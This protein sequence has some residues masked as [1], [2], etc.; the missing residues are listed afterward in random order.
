[1]P[2]IVTFHPD[3]AEQFIAE[4]KQSSYSGLVGMTKPGSYNYYWRLRFRFAAAAHLEKIVVKFTFTSMAAYFGSCKAGLHAADVTSLPG[5]VDVSLSA[6][7]GT[8]E[9]VG[10]FEANRPYYIWLWYAGKDYTTAKVASTSAV[11]IDGYCIQYPVTLPS[12]AGYTVAPVS[13]YTTSVPYGDDFKFM[14]AIA[15]GYAAGPAF[16]VKANGVVLTAVDGVY[17]I[18][19]ITYA[20]TVTVEG[21]TAAYA[22]T[23]TQGEGYTLTPYGGATSPVPAGGSYQFTLAI[24]SG[25]IQGAA[26]AVKANGV[27]LT[28]DASGIYTLPN[29]SQDMAVTVEGVT[30]GGLCYIDNGAG[31]QGYLAY[32][33][34]G[35]Q[36][37]H[38]LPYVDTGAGWE[39]LT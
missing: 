8:A 19:G 28:P 15:P 37:V 25:Y 12:G 20:Q 1:M 17:T 7:V 4:A 39:L 38:Y 32:I 6:S 9:L 29:I 30:L 16:A 11:T 36:F 34:T 3:L 18:P 35:T 24:A 21:V 14:V 2:A 10:P 33:D 22:V 5:G 26:F 13:G 31:F 27:A 23:L